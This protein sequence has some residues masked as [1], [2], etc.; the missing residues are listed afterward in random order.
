LTLFGCDSYPIAELDMLV[1]KCTHLRRLGVAG[2]SSSV[3]SARD[4]VRWQK[5]RPGLVVPENI[6]EKMSV[7][8]DLEQGWE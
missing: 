6:P 5:L 2:E 3:C 1:T 8:W 7:L 4:V